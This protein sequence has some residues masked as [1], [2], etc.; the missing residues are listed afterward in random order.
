M[1]R[2]TRR[3]TVRIPDPI[4]EVVEE[5]LV[6]RNKNPLAVRWTMTDFINHACV[7]ALLK[8][9]RSGKGLLADAADVLREVELPTPNGQRE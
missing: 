1:N 4:R 9:G 7:E 2:G 6:E 3:T 5:Y 8:R